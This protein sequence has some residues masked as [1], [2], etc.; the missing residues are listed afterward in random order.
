[1]TQ[2]ETILDRY[3][4]AKG[5]RTNFESYWQTLH[6]Y[7]YV[8][9][10]DYNK[11]YFPGTEL[12]TTKIYDPTGFEAADVLASGLMNYLT[13]STTTW[14]KLIHGNPAKRSSKNIQVYLDDVSSEINLI[15]NKSNFYNTIIDVYKSSGVYGTACL[16]GEEDIE[17]GI[18]FYSLPLNQ[19][20]IIENGRGSVSEY[21]IEFEY[22]AY[23][24][25]TK[26]GKEVLSEEQKNDLEQR[27]DNK[28]K[29]V[30]YIGKR[31]A[32]DDSKTDKDNMP[33]EAIW[34][35]IK[36]KKIV[37]EEGYHEMPAM[38]HRFDKR[39][40]IPWGFSPAM[41]ALPFVRTLNAAAKTN[42]RALMKRNDPP[43]AVP[44]NAFIAPFNANPRAINYY[45]SDVISNAQADIFTFANN[46]D[47][48]SGLMTIEYYTNAVNKMMY[49]D[50]FLA[51]DS[52]TKQMNNP[53]IVER[54]NEKFTM[55]GPAVGRFIAELLNPAI[56]RTIGVAFRAGR[57][58]EPPDEMIEDPNYEIE[59]VSSLAQTQKRNQLNSLLNALTASAQIAQFIPESLQKIDG[60]KAIDEIWA[61][62]GAPARVLRSD[63]EIVAIREG[64]AQQQ[65]AEQQL[66]AMGAG[67]NIAKTAAEGEKALYE[68][69]A[70]RGTV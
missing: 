32:R 69:K 51:F 40:F 22:T 47:P 57:L 23:Q 36:N 33:F 28:Y 9:S 59:Y 26:W 24:V 19:I 60:D 41:K 6:D 44:H 7:F 13:P 68:A 54:I 65:A 29:Y 15:L 5:T 37:S 27:K 2:A 50:V 61:M 67:A 66:A 10:A 17:D 63:E 55:L 20:A 53:E 42:L 58:P 30:L 46:G 4:I 49:R 1:M 35:D 70:K 64:I 38:V 3:K 39:P 34:V 21:Y 18:R 25:M 48:Q 12:D 31:Y 52:L 16:L 14:F 56:E 45:R 43:I 62:N 8:N 11:S